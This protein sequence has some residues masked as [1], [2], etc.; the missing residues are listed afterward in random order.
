MC[1]KIRV[2]LQGEICHIVQEWKQ[3]IFVDGTAI[4]SHRVLLERNDTIG[5]SN[6]VN[7]NKDIWF[8]LI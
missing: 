3:S 1:K 4:D 6:N 2:T 8:Q 5:G 7:E